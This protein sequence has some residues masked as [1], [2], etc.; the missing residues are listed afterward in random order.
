MNRAFK[1]LGKKL[2]PQYQWKQTPLNDFVYNEQF[3]SFRFKPVVW[4]LTN[5]V[6]KLMVVIPEADPSRAWQTKSNGTK[7]DLFGLGD[8]IFL[9]AVDKKN[10]MNKGETYLVKANE[11]IVPTRSM[12]VAAST[13]CQTG[14][15]TTDAY[16]WYYGSAVTQ[17]GGTARGGSF[18]NPD[19]DQGQSNR[20][21]GAGDDDEGGSGGDEGGS[22]G[23]GAGDDG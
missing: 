9:Y 15:D 2:F 5:G 3:K 20:G 6:R 8:N 11:K 22:G 4:E 10:L 1:A 14:T 16:R 23:G 19:D 21:G 18:S 17:V 12:K 13:H 7:E